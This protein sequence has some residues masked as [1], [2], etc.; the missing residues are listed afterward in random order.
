M[1]Y[2]KPRFRW[3]I[4]EV[5]QRAAKKTQ[6]TAKFWLSGLGNRDVS[7]IVVN[8]TIEFP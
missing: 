3:G 4:L 1:D 7:Y 6:R 8:F 5:A 2:L